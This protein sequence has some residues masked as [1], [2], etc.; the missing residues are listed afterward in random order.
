[1][2]SK[3]P[4]AELWMGA[5]PKAPSEV[6]LEGRWT[7][8]DRL[9]KKFPAE[10]LG[11]TVAQ[12][13]D[14]TL[15]YLYKLLA[16]DQPLSIQAHPNKIQAKQGFE[17]ENRLKIPLNAPHRNYKDRS[18]KPELICALTR[19]TVLKGFRRVSEMLPL[20]KTLC[21]TALSREIDKLSA[22]GGS[23]LKEFFS[24]LLTLPREK[25]QAVVVE[26]AENAKKQT[27]RHPAFEWVLNLHKNYPEDIGVLSPAILNL[28][29]L[30]PGEALFLPAGELHAYLKGLGMEL[31]ANSDNVLRGGLTRKHIDPSELLS[32]VSFT[33]T[34]VDI[35]LPEKRSMT[36]EVYPVLAEEFFLSVIRVGPG[37][38]HT[39]P[40]KHSA[41]ILFCLTG[42]GVISYGK[43]NEPVRFSKGISIII[44]ADV[45]SYRIS[46]DAVLYKAG[47]PI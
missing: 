23:G 18:H 31:M 2:P 43:N 35:L 30:A 36:E 13:F 11:E 33:E 37:R 20:L 14:N 22:E 1:M 41:D 26:A 45:G 16:A 7:P 8:V 34:G 47:V 39:A 9:I 5:H 24:G 32:V 17:R 44:P 28:I 19:F 10:V 21:P 42:E 4:W 38:N 27:G 29:I 25:Q 3:E 46:G 12:N 15:P 40:E 6:D